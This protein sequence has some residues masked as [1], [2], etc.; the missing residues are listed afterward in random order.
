M[1]V[2]TGLPDV[3]GNYFLISVL[4]SIFLKKKKKLF[5]KKKILFYENC[6]DFEKLFV[7]YFEKCVSNGDYV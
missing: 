2:T 3:H 5:K 4:C 1:V 6:F 7:I